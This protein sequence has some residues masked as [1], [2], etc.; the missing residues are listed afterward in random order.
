[1]ANVKKYLF[2]ALTLGLIAAGGALLIGLTNWAT[3]K[4]IDQNKIAKKQT[5]VRKIYKNDNATYETIDDKLKDK[6]KEKTKNTL[7]EYYLIKNNK[8]ELGHA[9]LAEGSNS[10]GKIS[11]LIGFDTNDYYI[12]VYAITNEQTYK[13]T[14]ETNYIKKINDTPEKLDDISVKCGATYGATTV[15]TM[16]DQAKAYLQKRK[17]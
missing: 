11:L 6:L 7:R 12:G 2:T 14:L 17:A 5:G 3:Y 13:P 16:I 1:M 8:D 9:F 10:Y 15:K 4:Q